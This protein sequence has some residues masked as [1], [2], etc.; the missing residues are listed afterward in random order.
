MVG[1]F[2]QVNLALE[3]LQGQP[4]LQHRIVLRLCLEALFGLVGSIIFLHLVFNPLLSYCLFVIDV[5]VCLPSF[6]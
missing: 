4:S 3:T 6:Q 5:Q 1:C 2:C